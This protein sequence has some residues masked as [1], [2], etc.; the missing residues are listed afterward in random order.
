MSLLSLVM[1]VRDAADLL[2]GFF[3]HHAGLWDEAVVVDTGSADRTPE[4]AAEA[5]A[6]VFRQPWLDDFS[7]PR[8][9]GLQQAGGDWILVLDADERIAA[10]DFAALRAAAAAAADRAWLQDTINYCNQRSH[11]EW[12]PVQ[13]RYPAEEGICTGYFLARRVGLFP[14]RDDLRFRGRIHESVLPACQAIGL[15]V[16]ALGIPVHHYGYVRGAG[17]DEQR[18]ELYEKLAAAKLGDDPGDWSARLEYASA[19][20][21]RGCIEAADSELTRLAAGPGHLRPVARGR[22]LLGRL[23]REAGDLAAAGDLLGAVVRDDPTFLFGWLEW[24]RLLAGQERWRE[25]FAALAEA[26]RSCGNDEPL[27]DREELLALARTG[28]LVAARELADRVVA[29]CPGW[30]ELAGVRDRLRAA[31]G[32]PPDRE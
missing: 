26:R 30:P 11:L 6:R 10:R 28:Q 27:L 23:R 16:E 14:R 19:L 20:L 9:F 3:A 22:F 17:V 15:R 2:P 5:G 13:G 8:N 25:V 4:R 31:T 29:R 21:E 24:L 12:R 18:R 7:A 32:A 1:I